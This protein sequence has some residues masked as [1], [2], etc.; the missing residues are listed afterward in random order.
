MYTF[1]RTFWFIICHLIQISTSSTFTNHFSL[2]GPLSAAF[3]HFQRLTEEGCSIDVLPDDIDWCDGKL[4]K[5]NTL[6]QNSVCQS[7]D[8]GNTL[9]VCRNGRWKSKSR[10]VDATD[11]STRSIKEVYATETNHTCSRFC[12]D[13]YSVFVGKNVPDFTY[14]PSSITLYPEGNETDIQYTWDFPNVTDIDGNIVSVIQIVGNVSNSTFESSTSPGTSHVI[15][16]LATDNDNLNWTCSFV[17]TSEIPTCPPIVHITNGN[18]ECSDYNNRDSVCM[19]TCNHG[20]QLNGTINTTCLDDGSWSYGEDIPQCLVTTCPLPVLNTQASILEVICDNSTESNNTNIDEFSFGSICWLKCPNDYILKND[21]RQS[22]ILAILQEKLEETVN[23]RSEAQLQLNDETKRYFRIASTNANDAVQQAIILANYLEDLVNTTVHNTYVIDNELQTANS[24]LEELL[25]QYNNTRV[26][27]DE[28]LLL[29]N[30]DMLDE[31]TIQ[32]L[33]KEINALSYTLIELNDTIEELLLNINNLTLQLTEAQLTLDNALQSVSQAWVYVNETAVNAIEKEALLEHALEAYILAHTAYSEAHFYVSSVDSS[34][35]TYAICISNGTWMIPGNPYCEDIDPPGIKCLPVATHYLLPGETSASVTWDLPEVTDNSGNFILNISGPQPNDILTRGQYVTEYRASDD[36]GNLSPVCHIV[37]NVLVRECE[38]ISYAIEDEFM[39]AKCDTY[40]LGTA[41]NL[42]C[43][44]S[45]QIYGANTVTC[46]LNTTT[47]TLYW[48]FGDSYCIVDTCAEPSSPDN[49]YIECMN[50]EPI[51]F[52]NTTDNNNNTDITGLQCFILC[53]ESYMLPYKTNNEYKCDEETGWNTE[54]FPAKCIESGDEKHSEYNF[55]LRHFENDCNTYD[56]DNFMDNLA[57]VLSYVM[58]SYP[59]CMN[60]YMCQL[61]DMMGECGT[62]TG[63]VLVKFTIMVTCEGPITSVPD[64]AKCD[65][66]KDG[67]KSFASSFNESVEV[68]GVLDNLN[69]VLI[70]QK[71]EEWLETLTTTTPSC[72]DGAFLVG[73]YCAR[74]GA[75]SFYD[76]SSGQ[77]LQCGV[78]SYTHTDGRTD[79]TT[80][81][82]GTYTLKK[83]SEQCIETCKAGTY[84][85]S[86]LE[87]CVTCTFGT[88]QPNNQSNECILCPINTWTTGEGSTSSD[89][90]IEYDLYFTDDVTDL[91]MTSVNE[92]MSIIF[93]MK[94]YYPTHVSV[95]LLYE[96]MDSVFVLDVTD[97]PELLYDNWD[98]QPLAVT[99]EADS[100]IMFGIVWESINQEITVYKDGE[101]VLNI[102]L[103]QNGLTDQLFLSVANRTLISGLSITNK[104]IDDTEMMSLYNDCGGTLTDSIYALADIANLHHTYIKFTESTCRTSSIDDLPDPCGIHECQHY[105]TCVANNNSI[106]YTCTCTEQYGG[107]FCEEKLVHGNWSEWYYATECSTTCGPGTRLIYRL[108]NNPSR[109]QYGNDCEGNSTDTIYCYQANCTECE[110]AETE[111]VTYCELE[112]ETCIASCPAGYVLPRGQERQQFQCGQSTNH[113]WTPLHRLPICTESRQPEKYTG[114]LTFTFV[115]PVPCDLV[116]NVTS[117][118][119]DIVSEQEC[120]NDIETCEVTVEILDCTTTGTRRK[121]QAESTLDITYTVPLKSNV[122]FDLVVYY[123]SLVMTDSILEAVTAINVLEQTIQSILDDPGILTAIVNGVTYSIVPGS[124]VVETTT[125]CYPGE[126]PV[127][128]V[129]AQCQKGTYEINGWCIYCDRGSYQH[130]SGQSSC[131]LCPNN[132]QTDTIGARESIECIEIPIPPTVTDPDYTMYIIL[133]ICIVLAILVIVVV[134]ILSRRFYRSAKDREKFDMEADR[135]SLYTD[136]PDIS[137]NIFFKRKEV[138]GFDEYGYPIIGKTRFK[139]GPIKVKDD[140]TTSIEDGRM[141]VVSKEPFAYPEDGQEPP[142]TYDPYAMWT[143]GTFVDPYEY[144]EIDS[145]DF[146]RIEHAV[147]YRVPGRKHLQNSYPLTQFGYNERVY[148]KHRK[149]LPLPVTIPIPKK[150]PQ[151]MYRK[152]DSMSIKDILKSQFGFKKMKKEAFEEG[153]EINTKTPLV[154]KEETSSTPVPALS[155]KKSSKKKVSSSKSIIS[156][157]VTPTRMTR[158]AMV[159]SP[160]TPKLNKARSTMKSKIETRSPR[161]MSA[162]SPRSIS[163]GS[164]SP[165]PSTSLNRSPRVYENIEEDMPHPKPSNVIIHK[166]PPKYTAIPEQMVM[167]SRMQM[168]PKSALRLPDETRPDTGMTTGRKSVTIR[169]DVNITRPSTTATTFRPSTAGLFHRSRPST[170]AKSAMETIVAPYSARPKSS[171]SMISDR[172]LPNE[173]TEAYRP[174]S[175]I[176]RPMTPADFHPKPILH[177]DVTVRRASGQTMFFPPANI[178]FSQN[179]PVE[180]RIPL[181]HRMKQMVPPPFVNKINPRGFGRQKKVRL[182][183]GSDEE[184]GNGSF[185]LTELPDEVRTSRA[186]MLSKASKKPSPPP[187]YSMSSTDK[188]IETSSQLG[189]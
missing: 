189:E 11:R 164:P 68:D 93:W 33:T 4:S 121:R 65:L 144:P 152:P 74:C 49:G 12:I 52:D 123:S 132:Q 14:C 94:Y 6:P 183:A 22:N 79:C 141:S 91:L 51:D 90:C 140:D 104:D 159:R 35:S 61:G 178:S 102:S 86:G 101:N 149:N 48:D 150:L 151:L 182:N 184:L 175:S 29:L 34:M 71:N 76:S 133:A 7:L 179:A 172:S 107:N 153:I 26:E 82:P 128:G 17:I 100:W 60:G 106:G 54:N 148:G 113:D 21:D 118:M 81:P 9:L 16:Y 99:M 38:D 167:P 3:E 157:S 73:S 77:C 139:N 95:E 23:A 122:T 129:C 135:V 137:Y 44:D 156:R 84:S 1:D 103:S 15:S 143:E 28:N 59:A 158:S 19:F 105:S 83:G 53:N 50:D 112:N 185:F 98:N 41:C 119:R 163:I 57:L 85:S 64:D 130:L 116:T 114:R 92:S 109:S 25:I 75:G 174:T 165:R 110:M 18:T 145:Y 80:C 166:P 30:D 10:D 56:L 171:H 146:P 58:I 126:V 24:E 155:L 138:L 45:F 108:C 115:N 131:T 2:E 124:A 181:E 55:L 87:P 142:F 180:H 117:E 62:L 89:D 173:I 69:I 154:D 72:P 186:S 177:T 20:Y 32:A 188:I 88:Y 96:N 37:I 176:Y 162:F 40:E 170:D 13:D 66:H 70:N 125:H 43:L 8:T 168:P 78:G 46:N 160:R 147:R 47:N 127:E 97:E 136:F 5:N 169:E 67:A 187:E 161:A 63:F 120:M 111:G 27:L 31:P 39:E 36:A 134:I 42:S